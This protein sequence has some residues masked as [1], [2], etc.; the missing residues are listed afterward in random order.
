ML[1]HSN[2]KLFL[3]TPGDENMFLEASEIFFYLILIKK[4]FKCLHFILK[5]NEIININSLDLCNMLILYLGFLWDKNI[6]DRVIFLL[7]I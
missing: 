2:R 5:L 7:S 4:F 3:V 6:V 1:F